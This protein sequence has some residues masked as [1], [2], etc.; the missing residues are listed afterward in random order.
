MYVDFFEFLRK[1]KDYCIAFIVIDVVFITGTWFLLDAERNKPV[2]NNTDNSVERLEERVN[3]LE[4]RLNSV[5]A[6]IDKA[7]ETVSGISAT[8]T[9]SRENAETIAGGI[10]GIEKRIDSCIQRSGKLANILEDIERT[11]KQRTKNP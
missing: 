6:R 4:Q 2:H 3:S 9:A 10:D 7:Q 5:S 1:N 8:V 11:N